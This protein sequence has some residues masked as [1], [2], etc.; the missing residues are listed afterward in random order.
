MNCETCEEYFK[1][2]V[3]KLCAHC[4]A[5]IKNVARNVTIYFSSNFVI[6][7]Y[8]NLIDRF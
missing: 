8:I 3:E 1:N 2:L 4:K 6:N 7:I 5:K